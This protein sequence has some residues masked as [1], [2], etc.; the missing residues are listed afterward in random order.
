MIRRTKDA[1]P[2]AKVVFAIDNCAVKL[3]GLPYAIKRNE[4]FS[5]DHP[6][7]LAQ[8]SLFSDIFPGDAFSLS[9]AVATSPRHRSRPVEA[10]TRAPGE[11]RE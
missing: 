1:E 2:N 5:A 3:R 9:G 8:P 6:I 7:V 4:A 10:A 11:V